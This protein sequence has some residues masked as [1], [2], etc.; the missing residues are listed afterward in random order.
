MRRV[1]TTA[2]QAQRPGQHG[3]AHGVGGSARAGRRSPPPARPGR[4]AGPARCAGRARRNPRPRRAPQGWPSR[5]SSL[6][7]WPAGVRPHAVESLAFAAAP[8]FLEVELRYPHR[9]RRGR[10]LVL[11]L[12]DHVARLVQVAVED[13]RRLG[14]R[15]QR[16]K[17]GAR[18]TFHSVTDEQRVGAVEQAWY[19]SFT[20]V[21]A[22]W[23]QQAGRVRYGHRGRRPSPWRRA[24]GEIG[25]H[26][27]AG[28]GAHVVGIGLESRPRSAEAAGIPG[29]ADAVIS[30]SP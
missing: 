16:A 23:P 24:R 14:Q 6:T 28:R 30:P 15:L 3:P 5:R 26:F 27:Q 22:G 11:A 7:S 9:L 19:M 12:L 1:K 10:C 29:H 4:P 13:H 2:G 25:D 17:S 20:S 18:N 8:A 21:T